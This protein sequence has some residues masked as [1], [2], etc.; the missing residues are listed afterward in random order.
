MAGDTLFVGGCGRFFEGTPA[1]MLNNMDKFATLPDDTLVCCAHEYTESNFK[2]LA[3]IDAAR[4][5]AR[6]EEI[7]ALRAGFEPTVPSTIGDEKRY[8][9]FMNCREESVQSSV[10]CAG[11]PENTMA[12]LR[13][14]KNSFR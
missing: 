1:Q 3:S 2:F 5:G 10:D 7:R 4:C 13:E 9:L 12:R 11:S 6:Y 14:L 8:N